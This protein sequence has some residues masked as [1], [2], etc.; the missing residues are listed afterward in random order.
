MINQYVYKWKLRFNLYKLYPNQSLQCIVRGLGH[1]ADGEWAKQ[2]LPPLPGNVIVPL[3]ITK[4]SL[5][6][7][8]TAERPRNHQIE[9]NRGIDRIDLCHSKDARVTEESQIVT[10]QTQEMPQALRTP[11]PRR[12]SHK[13]T[14]KSQFHLWFQSQKIHVTMVSLWCHYGVTMELAT[15]KG[16]GMKSAELIANCATPW[17]T[18]LV[19][20]PILTSFVS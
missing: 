12:W 9:W 14:K 3:P 19:V 7:F 11:W 10:V 16:L 1:H 18:T 6:N 17:L 20:A 5:K 8:A 4:I 13:A 15:S 2:L